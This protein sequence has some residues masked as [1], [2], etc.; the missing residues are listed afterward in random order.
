MDA[1]RM[2]RSDPAPRAGVG[3]LDGHRRGHRGRGPAGR[4]HRAH[5]ALHRHPPPRAARPSSTPPSSP[6]TPPP[7]PGS[8]AP[9][10]LDAC[11]KPK[12]CVSHLGGWRSG[13]G[14]G[15]DVDADGLDAAA[16]L[17]DRAG[18]VRRLRGADPQRAAVAAAQG[19]GVG[20]DGRRWGSTRTAPTPS[21]TRMSPFS[22][23]SATHTA[24]S[25]S[26][27]RPSGTLGRRSAHTRG[28]AAE[29]SGEQVVG[30]QPLA[31][32]LGH[33]Q[34][35]A[36]GPVDD[37]AAVREEH[38]VDHDPRLAVGLDAHERRAGRL[39]AG[40]DV[41]AEAAHVGPAVGVDDELVPRVGR[42]AARG[43]TP[44][45]G[46]PGR[47]AAAPAPSSTRRAGGRRAA[48]RARRGDRRRPRSARPGP[49]RSWPTPGRR[50][51]RRTRGARRASAGSRGTPGGRAGRWWRRPRGSSAALD[52]GV[53]LDRQPDELVDE[54]PGR[55][56]RWPATASGTSRSGVKPG[57][58]L[59][60]LSSRPR[61]SSS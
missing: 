30:R 45:R 50:G 13:V 51:S 55:G 7:D 20:A 33:D 47:A 27:A 6:P 4:R 35:A 59:S 31:P 34:G 37:H 32:G 56:G 1:G 25:A 46:R 39:V 29:P 57:I 5:P 52:L 21:I 41:V 10:W 53:A 11:R 23:G 26:T 48:S 2:R 14:G 19:A 43:R 42:E 58:V 18:R 16:A 9:S 3:L 54:R 8:P 44:A 61:P 36:L 12:R 38:A 24:P 22:T 60:S 40:L 49:P 28:R 17:A 15:G